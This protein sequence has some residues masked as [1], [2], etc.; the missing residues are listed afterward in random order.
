MKST[1]III[2]ILFSALCFS[3]GNKCDDYPA[4]DLTPPIFYFSIIDEED[5]DLFFGKDSIYDPYN[6]TLEPEDWRLY[7]DEWTNCFGL[8]FIEGETSFFYA[9][10][11]PNRTDT[12]KVESRF[13][14]WYEEPKGCPRY[15]IYKNDVF[16]NGE[17]I[18]TDC[19]EGQ[20]YK[21]IVK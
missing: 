7:I 18:C 2:I 21:I 16:F 14:K 17:L 10:F 20:I 6:I 5:N 13:V 8:L 9:E 4:I 3:C 19:E 15:M 12:I 11:I 1:K